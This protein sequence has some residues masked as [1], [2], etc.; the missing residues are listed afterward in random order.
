MQ[1]AKSI[2]IYEILFFKSILDIEKPIFPFEFSLTFRKLFPNS[3]SNLHKNYENSVYTLYVRD[4]GGL[5]K[6]HIA[7]SFFPRL[8]EKEICG[9]VARVVSGIEGKGGAANWPGNVLPLPS[10]PPLS[11]LNF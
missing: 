4:V 7:V 10:P 9:T 2:Y 5:R 3:S 8:K 1:S 6:A 11:D